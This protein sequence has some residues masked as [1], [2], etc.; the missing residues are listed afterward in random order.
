MKKV[1]NLQK[2][3]FPRFQEL[4]KI[5]SNQELDTNQSS[6]KSDLTNS[7]W[8]HVQKTED[9]QNVLVKF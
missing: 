7:I 1:Q 8:N 4:T 2:L 5:N 9:S 3:L 6:N